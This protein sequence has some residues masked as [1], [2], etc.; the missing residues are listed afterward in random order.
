MLE[1]YGDY[2]EEV[3]DN[4]AARSELCDIYRPFVRDGAAQNLEDA[5]DADE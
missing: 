3:G 5:L 2:I 1:Q 4:L